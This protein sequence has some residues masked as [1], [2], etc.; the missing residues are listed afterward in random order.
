[1]DQEALIFH[2][3]SIN[4]RINDINKII[5][6]NKCPLCGKQLCRTCNSHSVP[7]MVLK[8]L[9]VNGHLYN[10]NVVDKL[11]F[12]DDEKGLNNSG[13]FHYICNSCDNTFFSDYENPDNVHK[14]P[15]NK[16][17]TEIAVKNLLFSM[18][19]KA[20]AAAMIKNDLR[21]RNSGLIINLEEKLKEVNLDYRDYEN[22]L[23]TF[24]DIKEDEKNRY[25]VLFHTV[26]PYI[27]PV[28]VQEC[29]TIY[30]DRQ[31]NSIN[32][33]A[34]GEEGQ[35][36]LVH[37]CI[38]PYEGSTTVLLFY[39]DENTSYDILAEQFESSSV[40]T[41]LRYINYYLFA[42]CENYYYSE[43]IRMNLLTNEK[44]KKISRE[45]CGEEGNFGVNT[46]L[47]TIFYTPVCYDEIPFVLSAEYAL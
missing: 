14:Y 7:R 18:E 2:R 5:K 40:E 37:L 29:F 35:I 17:L 39:Y 42:F 13:T 22:Y 36:Q 32:D 45:Y 10:K 15:T 26:L 34:L 44:I 28:A 43:K 16:V 30:K 4:K 21:I 25:K 9:E 33:R 1:M 47:E 24:I 23:K 27:T 20:F 31:G 46:I 3:K 19:K 12:I 41:N 8:T 6:P 38:F 11:P